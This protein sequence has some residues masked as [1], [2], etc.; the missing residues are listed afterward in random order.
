MTGIWDASPARD[1]AIK[2]VRS[3]MVLH[4]PAAARLAMVDPTAVEAHLVA[5]VLAAV[6][7]SAEEVLVA[8][9]EADAAEADAD[10]NN[11]K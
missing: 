7:A 11:S 10:K 6:E 1:T 3:I 8:V 9:A 4:A 5:E 2:A